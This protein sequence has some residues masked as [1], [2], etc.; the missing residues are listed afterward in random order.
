M[1]KQKTTKTTPK[2][3]EPDA[4][5]AP[6]QTKPR[7]EA[8]SVWKELLDEYFEY[9]MAL[10]FP[11]I[12]ADIDWSKKYESL[13]KE[14][15]QIAR[16]SLV[17]KRHADKL[18]KV[19]LKNGEEK[20]LLLHIEIQGYKDKDFAER[21]YIYN[22]LIFNKYKHEV[23]S[24]AIFTDDNPSYYPNNYIVRRWDFSL[25][26]VFPAVKV[27]EYRKRW[28][29]L[30]ANPNPFALVIMAHLKAQELRNRTD[31]YPLKVWKMRLV[32]M[33]FERGYNREQIVSLFA[34][35]DWMVELPPNLEIQFT[36]DLAQFSEE[37]QMPYI[38]SIERVGEQKGRKEGEKKT[39]LDIAIMLSEKKFGNLETELRAQL[40]Q[41]TTDQLKDFI[42][43]LSDFTA[44]S[45]LIEW[46]Q[47]NPKS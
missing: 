13:D 42:I 5:A 29:E 26:F 45:Q 37:K 22:Y 41:L 6:K 39:A 30:E 35:I 12:H 31:K 25:Q 1:P 8:D 11:A 10:L 3:A 20:W 27:L 15:V 28:A 7:T 46:L 24:L 34:F 19:F 16:R 18:V 2:K 40:E 9:L 23:I 21:T 32:R 14:L 17:G 43:A 4:Q 38:T 44:K 33:M 36:D 47:T